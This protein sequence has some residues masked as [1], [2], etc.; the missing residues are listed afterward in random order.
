M[1]LI[2]RGEKYFAR[3]LSNELLHKEK[4]GNNRSLFDQLSKRQKEV[5]LLLASGYSQQKI[6]DKLFITKKVV[7]A[8]K[9]EIMDLFGFT[10]VAQLTIYCIQQG[11]IKTEDIVLVCQKK[12]KSVRTK[13]KS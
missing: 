10:E 8:H 9:S 12:Q 1:K 2:L 4:T 6:A 11:L 7:S 5:A 13:Q 3:E